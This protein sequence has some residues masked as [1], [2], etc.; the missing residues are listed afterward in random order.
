MSIFSRFVVTENMLLGRLE[1]YIS[2]GI[3]P[4]IDYAIENTTDKVHVMDTKKQIL[5]KYPKHFH[6]IKL[7]SIALCNSSFLSI[8][9]TAKYNNC[10]LLVDAEDYKI[11]DTIDSIYNDGC[12]VNK[13]DHQLFKTYQ[14]YRKDMMENL[15]N[16]CQTYK[17]C[18]LIHNIKLVRGAYIQK[19]SNYGIIHNSKSETDRHY[20]EAVKILLHLS[21]SNSKMNVIFAT[22]NKNSF[23]IIKNISRDN[24][25]HASLM[26]FDEN[27]GGSIQK[28]VHLPFGPFYYT[29]PYLMRRLYEN[30]KYSD[31]IVDSRKFRTCI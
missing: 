6:S 19:D 18:G 5:K 7:S 12:I 4:I 29:Y 16:D 14:M 21:K 2:K 23:D 22:H 13:F 20:D 26:G 9:E 30:N 1:K 11:Q 28:M 17:E 24:V 31:S 27:F 8:A 10:K 25:F 15:L 3:I